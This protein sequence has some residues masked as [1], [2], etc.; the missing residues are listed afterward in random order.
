MFLQIVTSLLKNVN[1][2][3]N[4]KVT[5]FPRFLFLASWLKSCE[6]KKPEF[7][8]CSTESIQEL[9]QNVFKGNYK[10]DGLDSVDPMLLD[11]ISVL[12]GDGPVSLNARLSNVKFFGFSKIALYKAKSV[13]KITAE[14]LLSKSSKSDLKLIITR[15]DK[16]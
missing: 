12:Q 5:Q 16:S 14:L 7:T 6:I 11:K 10:I 9:F 3:L 2:W 8:N 1:I 15:K 4:D 13:Q